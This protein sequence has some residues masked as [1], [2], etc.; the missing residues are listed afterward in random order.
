MEAK[1]GPESPHVGDPPLQLRQPLLT[2]ALHRDR[3]TTEARRQ[4]S[5]RRKPMLSRQ[6]HSGLG[7]IV[8]NSH[9]P[10]KLRNEREATLRKGDTEGMLQLLRQC[11]R[12]FTPCVGLVGESH[13]PKT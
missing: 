12:V 3:P 5:P 8:H 13:E 1:F 9:V 6:R 11:Q 7:L 2:P 4:G 10:A